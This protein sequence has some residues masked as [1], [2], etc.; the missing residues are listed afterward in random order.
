L[1]RN[2]FLFFHLFSLFCHKTQKEIFYHIIALQSSIAS[3]Y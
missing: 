1:N 2:R 3:L